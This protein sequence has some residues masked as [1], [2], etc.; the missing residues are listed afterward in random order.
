MTLSFNNIVQCFNL[1]KQYTI[2]VLENAIA[3]LVMKKNVILHTR[4]KKYKATI[5]CDK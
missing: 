5:M 4:A 3:L 2:I 1:L